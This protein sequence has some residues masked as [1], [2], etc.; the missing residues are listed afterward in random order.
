MASGAISST[1]GSGGKGLFL[2]ASSITVR[3]RTGCVTFSS[4]GEASKTPAAEGEQTENAAWAL[5]CAKALV[6]PFSD[7]KVNIDIGL[8]L[9][10]SSPHSGRPF[11]DSHILVCISGA[12]LGMF[13]DMFSMELVENGRR[14]LG[15]STTDNGDT[16]DSRAGAISYARVVVDG[17]DT[18]LGV[19]SFDRLVLV[20]V[21]LRMSWS[22]E[23]RL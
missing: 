13:L 12:L 11:G 19:S 14:G 7:P 10:A 15:I 17:G 6:I 2:S 22:V 23:D 3:L 5:V 21:G 1:L 18:L 16:I 4:A 20:E 8:Y 9:E